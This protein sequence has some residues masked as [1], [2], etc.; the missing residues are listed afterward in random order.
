MRS[1]KVL[2]LVY[3]CAA[4]CLVGS[5]SRNQA[6]WDLTQLFPITRGGCDSRLRVRGGGRCALSRWY[7]CRAAC[8]VR[9]TPALT[10]KLGVVVSRP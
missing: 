7:P 6:A 3:Y 10:C 8:Q 1:F 9:L 5:E 2:L 4:P